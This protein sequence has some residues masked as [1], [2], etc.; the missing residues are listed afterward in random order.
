MTSNEQEKDILIRGNVKRITFQTNDTGFVVARVQVEGEQELVTLTGNR[1]NLSIGENIVARGHYSEHPKF[2]T[3]FLAYNVEHVLPT[4]TAGLTKYLGSGLISGIGEKTAARIVKHFGKDVLD[5]LRNSPQRLAEVPKISKKKAIEL[6]EFLVSKNE[7]SEIDRFFSEYDIQPALVNKIYQKFGIRSI[8]IVKNNPYSLAYHIKG[9]G[10]ITAD[11]IALKL[12]LSRSSPQR[13][14]SGL[15]YALEKAK[16]DGHCF[17]SY[18]DLQSKAERLLDLDFSSNDLHPYLEQLSIANL[19]TIED[20]NIY[21]KS[22]YSAEESVANFLAFRTRPHITPLLSAEQQQ[23][24]IKCAEKALK[25]SLSKEQ[26]EAVS[27]AATYPLLAITGGPGCGKTT[28]IKALSTLFIK[29]H[30]ILALA[31]PTGKAAQRMS[32]VCG[33]PACTIHRLLGYDPIK[34]A[35]HYGL[36]EPLCIAINEDE[37]PKQV[38]A[39]I[40]DEA[41]MIDISL[42]K[43]LFSSIPQ[44]ATLILVGDKDQ[45]PSVGP[46]RLFADILSCPEIKSVELTHLYRRDEE[47]NI[48]VIAHDVRRILW[49]LYPNKK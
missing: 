49:I 27:L 43:A 34:N 25:I 24:A 28:V 12:G 41:S 19:I 5:I 36:N 30:K 42:A 17:L 39:V 37:D 38:D 2:G 29:N 40:V 31:A 20:D 23:D 11:E 13:L 44:N 6:A 16:E 1:L 45:L 21:L 10:F 8:E 35:F 15:F 46:G 3:Q 7:R 18:Q 9:I 33:V 4:T 48:S 47:S 26:C 14:Q 32:Q 22:L